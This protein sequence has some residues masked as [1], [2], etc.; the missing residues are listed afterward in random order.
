[1]NLGQTVGVL[2]LAISLYIL[3]Q[4]RHVLLLVFAAVVLATTI[5]RLVR[6]LQRRGI[7]RVWAVLISITL[8][9]AFLVACFWLIVVPLADEFRQLAVLLPKGLRQLNG[10]IDQM[11]GSVPDPLLPYLPDVD[12]ITQQIQPLVNELVGRSFSLVSNSLAVILE[13]LL[14]TVLTLML[15]FDP[16]AYRKTLV[17]LF[18]SFYRRRVDG[19]LDKCEK[20]LRGWVVGILFNMTT[21]GIFSVIGLYALGI[22]LA[23]AQGILAGLLMFI[24]NIGPT[25]SVIP[26][27]AIALLDGS[28]GPWKS[29]GVL[30]L[31][32]GSHVLES[33]V[34]TPLVMAKQV[35]LLPAGVLLAQLFFATVFGFLGLFL[36]I[37]LA[38]VGQ[39][40]LQEVLIKDVLDR[41]RSPTKGLEQPEIFSDPYA[42][43]DSIPEMLPPESPVADDQSGVDDARLTRKP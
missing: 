13:V 36:A 5:N 3:W 1:M 8:L 27:M 16:P 23:L 35:S 21:I 30:G 17:R 20:A 26:P 33:H 15:L 42:G 7:K 28:Y 24:P 12:S 18:P 31:Y 2:A 41:W 39:V 11:R 6:K 10:W 34:L 4:I 14:V 37:P 22:K 9:I 19:I 29:V 43:A 25:I 32:V 38:V 40:W